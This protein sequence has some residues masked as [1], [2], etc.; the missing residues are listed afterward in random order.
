MF[1]DWKWTQVACCT[2]VMLSPKLASSSTLS[3]AVISQRGNALRSDFILRDFSMNV[4]TQTVPA[5]SDKLD[6]QHFESLVSLLSDTVGSGTCL[7][8]S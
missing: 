4:C 8:E 7:I 5:W 3:V 6:D 2:C 1:E